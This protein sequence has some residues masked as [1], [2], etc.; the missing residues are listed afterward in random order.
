M[1]IKNFN[2]CIINFRP[3]IE[4]WSLSSPNLKMFRTKFKFLNCLKGR[5]TVQVG[6]QSGGQIN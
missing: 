2:H 1:F 6:I 4:D 3:F 5:F